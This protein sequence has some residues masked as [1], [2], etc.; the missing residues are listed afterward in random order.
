M[1]SVVLCGSLLFSCAG[2]HLLE[3]ELLASSSM[4]NRSFAATREAIMRDLKPDDQ[5]ISS[6]DRRRL[7]QTRASEQTLLI[8]KLDSE[9]N[10]HQLQAQVGKEYWGSVFFLIFN[11]I[12]IYFFWCLRLPIQTIQFAET[13]AQSSSALVQGG[14][15]GVLNESRIF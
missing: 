11:T 14:A 8:C 15:F 5:I 12:S 4:P 2:R 13:N 1:L 3:T 7:Q 10:T 9:T 6:P